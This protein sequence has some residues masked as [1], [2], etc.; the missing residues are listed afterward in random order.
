MKSNLKPIFFLFLFAGLPAAIQ[1]QEN[2]LFSGQLSTE[3]G[4]I[5]PADSAANSYQSSR[6]LL[7]AHEE[8]ENGLSWA[9]EGQADQ[10]T[11]SNALP[12][13][14][15]LYPANN[16]FQLEADDTTASFSGSFNM[17]RLDRAYLKWVSGPLELTAGLQS[18]D[19]GSSNFYSPTHYFNPVPVLAWEPDIPLGSEGV[20]ANCFLFDDLSLEGSVRW[21]ADGNSEEVFRLIDRGIGITLTPSFALLEG[22]DGIGLELSG[23]FPDFQ[24]RFE[25][26]NWIYAN[27]TDLFEWVG[28]VSTLIDKT[29]VSLQCLQDATGGALGPWQGSLPGI[30]YL[31]A[32]AQR[33]LTAQWRLEATGVQP[34]NGG[35][36]L[37]WPQVSWA[38]E[39]EWK[40]RFQAQWRS[41]NVIYAQD[42]AG[43]SVDY[44]F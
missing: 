22:R 26:V 43:L 20:N 12:A 16:R 5:H 11:A 10:Q 9:L 36:F 23:T 18:F 3:A 17:A 2:V 38:F 21:L 34:L 6:A 15:L 1:A 44:S 33:D 29:K 37:F 13:N 25:G 32:S 24:V 30:F 19:N 7:K 28:A 41:S 27:N 31:F 35:P 8:F 42:Q 39:P 14:W 4:I 40:L